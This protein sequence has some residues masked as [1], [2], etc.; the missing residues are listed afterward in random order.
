MVP[1]IEEIKTSK[2]KPAKWVSASYVVSPDYRRLTNSIIKYGILSPIV[3][4]KNGKIIDGYHRWTVANEQNIKTV[5][6]VIVDCDDVDAM[7]LHIDMNRSRGVVVAK[8]LSRMLK[9]IIASG[10]YSYQDLQLK[11]EM[12]SDEFD[13]L[14]DGSLIKMRKIKQHNYSPAWVP[15]ESASGEDIRVERPTGHT[16]QV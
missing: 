7:L 5:P 8:Y 11:L 9:R 1:E 4:Q 16:E 13:V 14:A 10:K 3:C 12:T 6:V 15:I 2:L